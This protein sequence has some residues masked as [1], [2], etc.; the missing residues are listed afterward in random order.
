MRISKTTVKIVAVY[1]AM[2]APF[3]FAGEAFAADNSGINAVKTFIESLITI[4][5]YI[6]GSVA[7][8]FIIIGGYRY[9]TST[10]NPEKLESAKGTLIHAGIGL[11]IIIGANVL[12]KIVS[13]AAKG[14]F[15]Q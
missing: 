8:L 13:E 15:G 5:S 12:V 4:A 7:V 14:A 11:A 6:A 9:V 1:L 2:L 3:I 10:N